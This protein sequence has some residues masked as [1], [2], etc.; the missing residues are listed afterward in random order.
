MILPQIQNLLMALLLLAECL[1]KC[2][3]ILFW[4]LNVLQ[5]YSTIHRTFIY[6]SNIYVLVSGLSIVGFSL[7]RSAWTE[8]S[9]SNIHY[10][11]I[12]YF[13]NFLMSSVPVTN[14][15]EES[16]SM[17]VVIFILELCYFYVHMLEF[18]E[19][20]FCTDIMESFIFAVY[21]HFFIR[22]CIFCD[23]IFI[24][25]AVFISLPIF[26]CIY[27]IVDGLVLNFKL[28]VQVLGLCFGTY[29]ARVYAAFIFRTYDAWFYDAEV[30]LSL[31]MKYFFVYLFFGV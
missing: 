20:Y 21:I 7:Y 6:L 26:Y 18:V 24:F 9:I 14:I 12:S 31:E 23:A 22:L 27:I 17:K 11:P 28:M 19:H 25:Y 30:S 16:C 4:L 1:L 3:A 29:D 8:D 2:S 13:Q 10:L 15:S 5:L